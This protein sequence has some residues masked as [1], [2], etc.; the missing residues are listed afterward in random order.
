[1]SELITFLFNV[2]FSQILDVGDYRVHLYP[3]IGEGGQGRVYKAYNKNTNQ[4]VAAKSIKYSK[5]DKEHQQQTFR[6]IKTCEA[7]RNNPNIIQFYESHIDEH[8]IWM[9][10]EYCDMGN[11]TD[12]LKR[13]H[14]NLEEKLNILFQCANAIQHL[15]NNSPSIVHRDIKPENF[16]LK[17]ENGIIVVKATDFGL[18]KLLDETEH[19]NLKDVYMNTNCGTFAYMAPDFFF[20]ECRYKATVDI[21][22]LG[23]L[24]L[25]V[26]DFGP[27]STE[28]LPYSGMYGIYF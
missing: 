15:H 16:V 19:G 5:Q 10:M 2:L 12:F 25:A 6:E 8:S 23:I 26:L 22:A 27:D 24:L 11:I 14:P 4:I 9:I 28:L 7:L 3:A 1:M 13:K 20:E 18:A 17:I 21:F